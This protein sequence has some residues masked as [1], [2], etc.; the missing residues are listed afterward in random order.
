MCAL[1]LL[2]RQTVHTPLS[3]AQTDAIRGPLAG[4]TARSDPDGGALLPHE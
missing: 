3:S 1:R 2:E 4:P